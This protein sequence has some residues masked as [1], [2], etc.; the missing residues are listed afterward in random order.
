MTHDQTLNFNQSRSTRVSSVK[1]M[2]KPTARQEEPLFVVNTTYRNQTSKPINVILRSGFSVC[3]PPSTDNFRGE[4]SFFVDVKYQFR[5]GVILDVLGIL[6]GTHQT[7]DPELRAVADA[8][9]ASKDF[10]IYRG[11]ECFL[12]Y[13]ITNQVITE[14]NGNVYL[15]DLDIVLAVGSIDG[16]Y[17]PYSER[18]REIYEAE[19]LKKA[20]FH[21]EI[22]I[23]D[24]FKH[25]GDRFVNLFGEIYKVPVVAD[26]CLKPGVWIKHPIEDEYGHTTYKKVHYTFEEA[27]TS[28]LLFK[29]IADARD[30]GD[31]ESIRKSEQETLK[32][33]HQL[34][35]AEQERLL[36][37]ERAAYEKEAQERKLFLMQHEAEYKTR[38]AREKEAL[39][40]IESRFKEL[41]RS[42]ALEK[43]EIEHALLRA[44]SQHEHRS[45]DRKDT[46]EVVKYL[47]LIIGAG[48]AIIKFW[49]M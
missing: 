26:R 3:I 5:R 44:K 8:M 16:I 49:K 21:Y 34:K 10:L 38:L 1:A 19:Q 48:A 6:D 15:E 23:V 18:G 7:T 20:G 22:K 37:Q 27:R 33:D 17:H 43:Q 40:V 30:L 12:S 14:A 41:E 25:F 46:S 2:P 11:N 45:L 9:R 24:P 4:R 42:H 13:A 39:T 32:A 47:P 28:L 36:Q 35:L 31:P 29:T